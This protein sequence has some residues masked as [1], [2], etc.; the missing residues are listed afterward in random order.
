M[1]VFEDLIEE[2]REENL[3]EDTVINLRRTAENSQV[4][5][6]DSE[7]TSA[8]D[9][10]ETGSSD[11]HE[12]NRI[13]DA[14]SVPDER[15]CYR[16]RA[17]D[18]VSSLQM[19]EHVLSGIEREHMKIVP[20][21]YDDLQAKKALHKFLQVQGDPKT[22]AYAEAEFNLVRETEAWNTALSDRDE[23]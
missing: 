8:A 22:S 18:E 13:E 4:M 7:I 21:T 5:G 3:L 23:K 15:D 14:T 2:L 10:E 1:N 20:A 16:K 6:S 12:P 11:G 9:P 19:V 17:M